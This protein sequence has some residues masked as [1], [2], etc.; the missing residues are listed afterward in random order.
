LRIS[1]KQEIEIKK[2]EKSLKSSNENISVSD[3]EDES[4]D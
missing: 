4:K 1:E 2:H 3:N